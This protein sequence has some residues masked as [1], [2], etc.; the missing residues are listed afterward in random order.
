MI[1]KNNILDEEY[2]YDKVH[3]LLNNQ[4]VKDYLKENNKEMVIDMDNYK[5]AGIFNDNVYCL[6]MNL[7]IP[8]GIRNYFDPNGN[9]VSSDDEDFD[10]NTD[11]SDYKWIYTPINSIDD[12]NK[13]YQTHRFATF[14]G[15]P[16]LTTPEQIRHIAYLLEFANDKQFFNQY[17][18]NKMQNELID[19]APLKYEKAM[20]IFKKYYTK[21][22]CN[23]FIY[24]FGV[25]EDRFYYLSG[26]GDNEL[27][28]DNHNKI[29]KN[30]EER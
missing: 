18:M 28:K 19:S 11:Y 6:M 21:E 15:N 7:G 8:I 12:L 30:R 24:D 16:E 22:V 29:N 23:K 5:S 3:Q 14:M 13:Y 17:T 1:M 27:K 9:E 20:N 26:L 25:G 4:E 2:M 10:L